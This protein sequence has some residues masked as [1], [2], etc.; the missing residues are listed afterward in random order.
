ML[1][2]RFL[3][4]FQGMAQH[5]GIAL[6]AQMAGDNIFDIFK[7][8]LHI[9]QRSWPRSQ[10]S[11]AQVTYICRLKAFYKT[12]AKQYLLRRQPYHNIVFGVPGAGVVGLHRKIAGSK[13]GIVGKSKFRLV[14]TFL[15]SQLEGE[16]AA[17]GFYAMFF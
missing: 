10:I 13:C 8:V 6:P 12:A 7:S 16:F 15:F 4:H 2:L 1:P 5:Q 3:C 9:S 11:I 17:I 14:L